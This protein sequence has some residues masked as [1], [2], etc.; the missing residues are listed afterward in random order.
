MKASKFLWN[1]Y[2]LGTLVMCTLSCLFQ[3]FL[4]KEAYLKFVDNHWVTLPW[5]LWAVVFVILMMILTVFL[6]NAAKADDRSAR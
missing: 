5:Q 1:G 3:D 4:G 2:F 6:R